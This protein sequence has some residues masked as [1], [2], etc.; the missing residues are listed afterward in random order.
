MGASVNQFYSCAIRPGFMY[1]MAG[2]VG[3]DYVVGDGGM[4]LE[5]INIG[6][7]IAA[8]VLTAP[9]V[10]IDSLP[11]LLAHIYKERD[12]GMGS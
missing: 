4:V 10:Y 12:D 7:D 3:G 1:R 5:F 2:W 9:A 11:S 8:S 6:F